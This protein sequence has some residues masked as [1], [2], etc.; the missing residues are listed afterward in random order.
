MGSNLDASSQPKLA[1]V[2]ESTRRLTAAEGVEGPPVGA[3]VDED[4]GASVGWVE[5]PP[6]GAVAGEGVGEGVGGR[7][8][9]ALCGVRAAVGDGVGA[10]KQPGLMSGVG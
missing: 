6:L 8:G 7:D 1:V 2:P 10:A 9:A 5:G 4:V 3:V